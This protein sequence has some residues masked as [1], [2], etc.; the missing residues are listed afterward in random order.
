METAELDDAALARVEDLARSQGD[1][2]MIQRVLELRLARTDV[3][4]LRAALLEQLG[5]VLAT[6]QGPS[7]A[8]VQVW[9]DGAATASGV[10]DDDRAQRLYERVIEAAP[11]TRQ[12]AEPLI[13]LYV[14][15]AQWARVPAAFQVLLGLLEARELVAL[16]T[17]FEEA[18]T[19]AGAAPVLVQMIDALMAHGSLDA[20]RARQLLLMRARA[21]TGDATMHDDVA[22]TYK[23]L[24]A[25][26]EGDPAA[27]LEAFAVFLA[28]SPDRIHDRRWLY[29]WRAAHAADQVGA[30]VA[31]AAAEESEFNAP[32]SALTLYQRAL[33]LDPERADVIAEVARL[34][35]AAGDAEGALASLHALRDRS[36]EEARATSS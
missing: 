3:P 33:E 9:L 14:R 2:A 28:G 35:G 36:D 25:D 1:G 16:V 8:A 7:E 32:D 12:A 31:W 21:L 24:L 27:A 18:A 10:G 13:E 6:V 22:A 30:L 4:E 17:G 15:T 11:A 26:S 5:D 19:V 23:R 34:Q 29:E 20:A